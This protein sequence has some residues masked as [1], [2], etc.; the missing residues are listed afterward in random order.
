MINHLKLVSV[1]DL[2]ARSKKILVLENSKGLAFVF[3]K[4]F[5]SN[6]EAS[7]RHSKTK[8]K[9]TDIEK[10]EPQHRERNLSDVFQS[11]QEVLAKGLDLAIPAKESAN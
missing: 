8:T 10:P 7:P 3:F 1:N 4:R 2:P 11:E 9:K 5:T 6:Q